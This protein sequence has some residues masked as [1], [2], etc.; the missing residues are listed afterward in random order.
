MVLALSFFGPAPRTIP[1][2]VC[3]VVISTGAAGGAD[4]A[5]VVAVAGADVAA[6]ELLLLLEPHAATSPAMTV[7]AAGIAREVCT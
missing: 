2:L 6:C 1:S 4:D 3:L 7:A 5:C